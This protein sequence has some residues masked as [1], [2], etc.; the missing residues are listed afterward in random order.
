MIAARKRKTV[1]SEFHS[2]QGSVFVS[3]SEIDGEILGFFKKLY[4]TNDSPRFRAGQFPSW[5][6]FWKAILKKWK[7]CRL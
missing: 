1:I 5:I 6:V 7:F 3:Q 2:D 4:R